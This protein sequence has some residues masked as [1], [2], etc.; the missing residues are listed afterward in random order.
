[1]DL[2]FRIPVLILIAFATVLCCGATWQGISDFKDASL[3]D[4]KAGSAVIA[5]LGLCLSILVGGTFVHFL[6]APLT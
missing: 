6:T 5:I 2:I 4:R 3:V 1:M